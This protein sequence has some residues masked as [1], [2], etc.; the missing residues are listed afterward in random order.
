MK[1]NLLLLSLLLAALFAVSC[2]R[3]EAAAARAQT[4]QYLKSQ[5]FLVTRLQRIYDEK[6]AL[7]QQNAELEAAAAADKAFDWNSDISH[8]PVIKRLQAD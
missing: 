2:Y 7:E 4:R 5:Q 1:L 6:I 3:G 8:S